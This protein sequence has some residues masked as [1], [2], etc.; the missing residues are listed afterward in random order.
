MKLVVGLGNPGAKY[1]GTRHNVGYEVVE[2]LAEK[3]GPVQFRRQFEGRI[4]GV[5]IGGERTLLLLPATYMNLSG[6]SVQPALV[7]Y[8]LSPEQ[9]LVLCDDLNLPVGKIRIRARGSDGGQKGLRSI[10]EQLG[11]IEYPR[12]RVGIGSPPP[13]RDAADFVLSRFRA[14]ERSEIDEATQRAADAV[15]LWCHSGI[16][17]C[18]NRFN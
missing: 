13:G 15:E 5:T 3:F 18:M 9:L 16:E 10:A 12:L 6:R 8:K 1:T 17:E 2:R 7:F 14:E 4:G 11:T